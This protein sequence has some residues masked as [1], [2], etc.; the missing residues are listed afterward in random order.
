MKKKKNKQTNKQKTKLTCLFFLSRIVPFCNFPKE[1][2]CLCFCLKTQTDFNVTPKNGRR[3]REIDFQRNHIITQESTKSIHNIAN[4]QVSLDCVT[5]LNSSEKLSFFLHKGAI[6]LGFLIL[7]VGLS[8]VVIATV[9]DC[10]RR[11][12]C[13]AMV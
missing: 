3:F 11:P 13:R 1:K 9:S 4:H 6:I 10:I 2:L 7:S 12:T 8:V 5:R